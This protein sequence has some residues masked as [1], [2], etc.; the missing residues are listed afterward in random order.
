MRGRIL[1]SVGARY[2]TYKTAARAQLKS[3]YGSVVDRGQFS[4][5]IWIFGCQRSGTTFLENLFRHDLR[6]AVFG[7]FSEL[8]IGERKT[9]LREPLEIKKLVLAKNAKYAVIRPLFESDR[10]LELLDI[11]PNSACVWLFRDAASVIDSMVRKWDDRFFEISREVESDHHNTWRLDPLHRAI[12]KSAGSA[13]NVEELYARYWCERNSLPFDL[14]LNNDPRV[15]YA[16]YSQFVSN[17]KAMVGCA[18][19]KL[20]PESVWRGFKAEVQRVNNRNPDR[21]NISADTY[22]RCDDLYGRLLQLEADFDE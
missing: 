22:A 21:L 4:G 5:V 8:T 19:R 20:G 3:F 15:I 2:E 9:V 6:S 11:F 12:V 16:S 18:L 7:E 1:G 10:A 13:A 14:G 17:P